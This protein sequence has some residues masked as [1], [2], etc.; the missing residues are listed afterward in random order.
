M[1]NTF[2][3]LV[4]GIFL[5]AVSGEA[6][7]VNAGDKEVYE[8]DASLNVSDWSGGVPVIIPFTSGEYE[9][10]F[11]NTN[12]DRTA[13]N[14]FPSVGWDY[15]VGGMSIYEAADRDNELL[16]TR[17]CG[18]GVT[19]E[20]AYA[21]AVANDA[22]THPF[23]VDRDMEGAAYFRDLDNNNV[24]GVTIEIT[25]IP[26]PSSASLIGLMV[27]AGYAIRRRFLV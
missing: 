18:V 4:L 6:V 5:C 14:A 19:P 25:K 1:K 26:E 13:W 27:L 8:L 23:T 9:L 20:A 2:V 12:P 7:L 15:F 11:L 24:G 3:L 10:K 17:Q 21:D 16:Q 22:L